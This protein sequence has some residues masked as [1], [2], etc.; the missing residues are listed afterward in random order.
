MY[1]TRQLFSL[2][3][4]IM[5]CTSTAWASQ[6]DLQGVCGIHLGDRWQ[7]VLPLI[8]EKYPGEWAGLTFFS[9]HK[10]N[11]GV[12]VRMHEV[13][14]SQECPFLQPFEEGDLVIETEDKKPYPILMISFKPT[15]FTCSEWKGLFEIII[16]KSVYASKDYWGWVNKTLKQELILQDYHQDGCWLTF[17][18]L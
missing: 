5:S 7:D 13:R 17:K 6:K 14:L 8:I 12:P 2:L 16:G 11:K 10:D 18:V 9:K 1:N 15:H 4:L 3:F